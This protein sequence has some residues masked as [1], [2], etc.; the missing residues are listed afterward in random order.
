[1]IQIKQWLH[2]TNQTEE[3]Y[4]CV[5]SPITYWFYFSLISRTISVI[6][7]HWIIQQI[8]QVCNDLASY[9]IS[10]NL[11]QKEENNILKTLHL[12]PLN[13]YNSRRNPY[14]AS[15]RWICFQYNMVWEFTWINWSNRC[16]ACCFNP[17]IYRTGN[18]IIRIF[19]CSK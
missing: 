11:M 14:L 3:D 5:V 9:T 6:V 19:I 2:T 18:N 17:F 12:P 7:F 15:S 10:R 16:T 1:M 4:Q 13:C 8:L